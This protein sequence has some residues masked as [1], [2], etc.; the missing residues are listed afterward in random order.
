MLRTASNTSFFKA[1]CSSVWVQVVLRRRGQ[2]GGAEE[3][4][5]EEEGEWGRPRYAG[6]ERRT[7]Q[8]MWRKC[9]PGVQV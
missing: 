4:A 3:R 6:Y 2:T 7:L 1:V 9:G 5:Q 8:G